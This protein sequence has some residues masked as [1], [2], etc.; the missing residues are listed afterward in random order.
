MGNASG[1]MEKVRKLIVEA[2]IEARLLDDGFQ[3]PFESSAVNIEIIDQEDR[4]LVQFSAP[5]LREVQP[6]PELF[7]WVATQGQ[8]FYFGAYHAVERDDGTVLLLVE[9]TLLGDCL[10][11]EEFHAALGSVASLADTQDDELQQQFGGKRF[12]DH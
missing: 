3:V 1:V 8:N 11:P 5:V 10:D 6:S 2:G 4:V 12:I 7:Q 9:Y